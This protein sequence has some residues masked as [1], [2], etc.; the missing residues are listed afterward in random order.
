MDVMTNE[1]WLTPAQ[2]AHILGVTTQ[3]VRQWLAQGKL[4][5]VWT[6]LGRIIDPH[7]VGQMKEVRSSR[8]R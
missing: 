3:R 1:N 7:S 8:S 6:P 5:H 4:E 2:A